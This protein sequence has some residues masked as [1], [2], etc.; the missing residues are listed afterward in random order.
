M[1]VRFINRHVHAYL[2]YPVAFSLMAMPFFLNLG[3]TNP[4]GKWLSV[5]TGIAA[6]VLTLLTDHELGVVRVLPYWFH[7][8]V[9]RI[10]GITFIIA[11]FALGF[12]GR[13]AMYYFVNG[14]T[15][16]T[17]TLLLNRSEVPGELTHAVA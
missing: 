11:P 7:L 10:V 6:F 1:N 16:F 17:V 2:D 5:A 12:G 14:A 3:S 15:V 4:L 8:V 9:D 13:D